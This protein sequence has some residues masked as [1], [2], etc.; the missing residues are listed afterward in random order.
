MAIFPTMYE[1]QDEAVK[2]FLP[3]GTVYRF[4]DVPLIVKAKDDAE[5]RRYY[6][7]AWKGKARRPLW[8]FYFKSPE[9]RERKVQ[10]T[11]DAIK[12]KQEHKQKRRQE[13]RNVKAGDY[14]AVMDVIENT[15]GYDQTNVD[16]YQ[17]IEVKPKSL[18]L[19]QIA[20]KSNDHGGPYGGL[21]APARGEFIGKPFL[22]KVQEN[23]YINF[24]HGGAKKRNGKPQRCSS[25]H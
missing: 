15:W 11:Y 10:N 22:K 21:C 19:Q 17:V 18:K 12:A 24:R 13:Q 3:G 1:T 4:K 23:G 6:A 9:E 20:S 7:V 16:F 5:R 8:N 25:Y 14:Y 2:A